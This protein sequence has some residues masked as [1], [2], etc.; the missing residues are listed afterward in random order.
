MHYDELEINDYP[1]VAR[2]RASNRDPLVAIEEMTGAKLQA[3]RVAFI[4][5]NG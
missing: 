3:L 5:R 2:Q 4:S 1:Q